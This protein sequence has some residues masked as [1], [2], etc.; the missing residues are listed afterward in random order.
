MFIS[1]GCNVH[2]NAQF[3]IICSIWKRI[4]SMHQ[5]AVVWSRQALTMNA[6]K[7]HHLRALHHWKGCV[8]E[9]IHLQFLVQHP[10][11]RLVLPLHHVRAHL[12]SLKFSSIV[13]KISILLRYF[14][15]YICI[16]LIH[17]ICTYTE[18][19]IISIINLY[20]VL[21]AKNRT[22]WIW[23]WWRLLT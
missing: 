6:V 23:Q 12:S 10:L 16:F 15:L 11:C 7:R 8:K 22:T 2:Y 1:S 4:T 18:I 5:M 21:S 13:I 19:F 9:V 20:F 14:I 3:L 17:L